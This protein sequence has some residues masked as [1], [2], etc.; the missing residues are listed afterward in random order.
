MEKVTFCCDVMYKDEKTGRLEIIDG[1]LVKN[2]VYTDNI[3][4]HPCP[5]SK[6]LIS[7]IS[8]LEDRVICIERFTPLMQKVLGLS[9]YNMYNILRKTHGVDID[10]FIWFKFDNESIKWENVKVGDRV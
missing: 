1:V 4:K 8:A 6:T 5:N 10:D 2:E 3:F 7:V 9:E